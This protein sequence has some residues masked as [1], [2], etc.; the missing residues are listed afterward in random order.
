MELVDHFGW[1][2]LHSLIRIN[3]FASKPSIKSSLKF[4]RRMPWARE[5]VETLFCAYKDGGT[6]ESYRQALKQLGIQQKGKRDAYSD[7]QQPKKQGIDPW[8]KSR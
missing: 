4:L 8:A 6:E 1:D 3:C 7:S 2:T 5:Q